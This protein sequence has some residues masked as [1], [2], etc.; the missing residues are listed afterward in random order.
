M[1]KRL[2][3]II[4]TTALIGGAFSFIYP[5]RDAIFTKKVAGSITNGDQMKINEGKIIAENSANYQ[6]RGDIDNS[7]CPTVSAKAAIVVDQETNQVL[8]AKNAHQSLPPASV[9]KML[10]F[11]I[12]LENFKEDDLIEISENAS[13]QISNKINMKPG[14]KI[15]LSDLLYGLMMISANDA[16][17][18]I[19]D[20]TDGGFDRFLEMA[21]EK[22]RL[23]G[24]KE[25][26]MKNPAGLD[27][28]GQ[29]SSV[30]DLATISRYALVEHPQIIEYAGKTTEHSVYAT[31][32]NE[33]H[34]WFGHLSHMLKAYKTMIAAKT[35]YT[36]SAGTT[37]IGIAEKSG[38]KLVVVIMGSNGANANSDV[39]TLLDYGFAY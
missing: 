11:S 1:K 14:E 7:P 26:V 22:V 2:L 37:Y 8:C 35:G 23:L 28:E 10:T 39:K 36:D 34:W 21:N 31:D 17:Y 27:D 15:K 25:T 30:F 9:I 13:I 38:R 6:P 18:A 32:H 5:R 33:P 29:T 24:L 19:A 3:L 16:A 20:A 4:I 12:A